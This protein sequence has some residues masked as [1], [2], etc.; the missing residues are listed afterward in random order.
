[1]TG[2]VMQGLPFPS[3]DYSEALWRVSVVFDGKPAWFG[4]ACDIDH[5]IVRTVGA[6]LV[7]YPTR[8]AKIIASEARWKVETPE[9]AIELKVSD[10][11]VGEIPTPRRT[12]VAAGKRVYE[13]PWDEIPPARARSV[14]VTV[15]NDGLVR[16]TFGEGA[17]LD[18]TGIV[19]RGRVHICGRARRLA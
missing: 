3:F 6:R 12:F 17:K 2:L 18:E 8:A 16:K 4:V 14:R 9:T 13:I 10:E 19:H 1:M 11:D 15:L 7:R 5:P